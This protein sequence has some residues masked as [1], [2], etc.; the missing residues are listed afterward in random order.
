MI[1]TLMIWYLILPI[2]IKILQMNNEHTCINSFVLEYDQECR[3]HLHNLQIKGD[4]SDSLES[5]R[6]ECSTLDGRALDDFMDNSCYDN[7][8]DDDFSI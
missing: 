7:D 2:L 4:V 6:D 8:Y 1:A 3:N 5:S